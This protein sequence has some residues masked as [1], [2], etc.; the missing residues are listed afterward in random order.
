MTYS[1]IG[2]HVVD[3]W[4]NDDQRLI[5]K[6]CRRCSS[7]S[8]CLVLT[9]RL[10]VHVK[11]FRAVC[12]YV[13]ISQ[14]TFKYPALCWLNLHPGVEH[15]NRFWMLHRQPG[16]NFQVRGYIGAATKNQNRGRVNQ[17]F[18][19]DRTTGPHWAFMWIQQRRASGV[20]ISPRNLTISL[21]FNVYQL[22]N[23][24][25]VWKQL[26]AFQASLGLET[27]F[28]SEQNKWPSLSSYVDCKTVRRSWLVMDYETQ[29]NLIENQCHFKR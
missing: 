8:D 15:K 19:G 20:N 26:L 29:G 24:F 2:I 6:L 9:L 21:E 23:C 12:S 11:L 1:A 28:G 27:G 10:L 3:K 18:Y 22:L 16:K 17:W 7:F 14:W 25:A 13:N 5:W 4:K